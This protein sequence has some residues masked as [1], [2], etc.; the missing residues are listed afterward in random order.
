MGSLMI[1]I[2]RRLRSFILAVL[3]FS[4]ICAADDTDPFRDLFFDEDGAFDVSGLLATSAGFF[5]VPII[6]TEPA[7]GYGGG[8]ALLFFHGSIADAEQ[9]RLEAE[10][11]GEKGRTVPPSISGV[12]GFGT[13]N[14]TW[15]AGLFHMGH[16]LNDDLRYLGAVFHADVNLGFYGRPDQEIP[17]IGYNLKTSMLL[18]QLMLRVGDS[19]FFAGGEYLFANTDTTLDLP[20]EGW[21]TQRDSVTESGLGIVLQYDSRDNTF[22]PDSGT[23]TELHLNR[24]DQNIGSDADYNKSRFTTLNWT[25]LHDRLVLGVR[26]D[27]QFSSGDIPFYML[28]FVHLRGIPAMRYQGAHTAVAETEMRWDYTDRWSLVAFMGS[29]WVADYELEDFKKSEAYVAGGGGLRYLM[30][31]AF[32]LRAG[33]DVAQGPE[34]TVFYLTV[35]SSWL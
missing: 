14:D 10:A 6:I 3:S 31:S 34:D 9:K 29:G 18:Q 13:E 11:R 26:G 32:H 8:A 7:V 20:I 17:E 12:A 22:S 1:N 15:G 28:P 16:Y 30:A 25:P 35:G 27:L 5:P 33:F 24:Y 21:P 4:G 19:D 23:K 2:H